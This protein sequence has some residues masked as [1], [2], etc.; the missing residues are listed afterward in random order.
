MNDRVAESPA[1]GAASEFGASFFDVG[2]GTGLAV[3][4]GFLGLF[5][6]GLAILLAR[7]RR[8]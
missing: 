3:L 2:L 4:A 7:A 1:A 8:A 6:A 5:I